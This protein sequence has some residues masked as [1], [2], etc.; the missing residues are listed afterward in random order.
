MF[1]EE[2]E[3]TD[4][5]M[6]QVPGFTLKSTVTG[7]MRLSAHVVLNRMELLCHV[8]LTHMRSTFRHMRLMPPQITTQSLFRR[9]DLLMFTVSVFVEKKIHRSQSSARSLINPSRCP[10]NFLSVPSR[11]SCA[12]DLDRRSRLPA[13][14]F[15]TFLGNAPRCSSNILSNRPRCCCANFLSNPSRC[16]CANFLGNPSPCSCANFL[17]NPSRCSCA[18]H[19]D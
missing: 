1:R 17:G 10:S 15:E 4:I 18:Q 11:W 7:A 16:S 2:I 13:S 19:L 9:H 14:N 5:F 6:V 12:Q 3:R 8:W